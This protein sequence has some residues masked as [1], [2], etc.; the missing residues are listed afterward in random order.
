MGFLTL[1]FWY[2]FA[3]VFLFSDL[4]RDDKRRQA[5]YLLIISL[6]LFCS[7][8]LMIYYFIKYINAGNVVQTRSAILASDLMV[9]VYKIVFIVCEFV[10][11]LLMGYV[12]FFDNLNINP[13]LK[14]EPFAKYRFLY[15]LFIAV[16]LCVYWFS[17]IILAFEV[18]LP[19]AALEFL[20]M[21][22][23]F[24]KDDPLPLTGGYYSPKDNEKLLAVRG[25]NYAYTK[26]KPAI[27]FFAWL[28]G[29]LSRFL[30]PLFGGVAKRAMSNDFITHLINIVPF[31]F[32]CGALSMS[33][34][35]MIVAVWVFQTYAIKVI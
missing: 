32:Y 25:Y 11:L 17:N 22:F 28:F 6:I 2:F 3:H 5:V 34:Y 7:L 24:S 21:L 14:L 8:F 4:F 9:G 15:L 35:A 16:F 33:A 20:V 29:P 31:I 26:F 18:A 12:K 10:L 1:F 19:F 13:S 23:L 30:A 27:D